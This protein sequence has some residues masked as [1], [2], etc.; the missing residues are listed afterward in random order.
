MPKYTENQLLTVVKAYA[1]S[2]A[3]PIDSTLVWDS[4]AEAETN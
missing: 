3:L 1:R 4:Q 2:A